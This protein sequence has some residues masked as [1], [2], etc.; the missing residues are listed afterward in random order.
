MSEL[1]LIMLLLPLI[2]CCFVLTAPDSRNNAYNVTFFTLITNI[3]IVLR[4][5]SLIDVKAAETEGFTYRWLENIRLDLYFRSEE[6][7]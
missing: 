4:L 6:R 1:I 5:F 2:G 3:L 7:R